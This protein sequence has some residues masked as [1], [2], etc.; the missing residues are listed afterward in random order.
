MQHLTEIALFAAAAVT[1]ASPFV[2]YLQTGRGAAIR[3]AFVSSAML[4]R[5]L[6]LVVVGN[7]YSERI[8]E[9]VAAGVATTTALTVVLFRMQFEVTIAASTHASD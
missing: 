9:L 5:A 6:A 3:V 4:L 8:G 1:L 7:N 2:R